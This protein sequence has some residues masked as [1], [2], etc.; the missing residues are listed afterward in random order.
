MGSESI[1]HKAEKIQLVG[2]KKYRG[3]TSF[4]S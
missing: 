1:A 3:K 4:A 2:Q